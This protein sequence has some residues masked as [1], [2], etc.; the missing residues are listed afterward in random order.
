MSFRIGVIGTG[1]I[2]RLHARILSEVAA[3]E[4]CCVYDANTEAAREVAKTHGVKASA[5]LEEFVASVDAATLATPTPFHFSIGKQLLEAGRHV[6]I[7]KPITENTDDARE[8]V[9]IAKGRG[10][11]LQVGHVERFNPVL[12]ALEN[13]LHQPRF[14][15]SHRLSPYPNRSTDIGVVLDLMIHDIEIILHLVRSPV[16]SV[17][18]VGVPV[19]SSSEDIAN[20]RLRFEN[21]CVANLT[22]SRVSPERMRKIRVFQEDCYLSLDYMKQEGF[23]YRMAEDH[24]KESSLLAKLFASGDTTIVSEFAGRKILREPVPIEKGEPLKRELADFVRCA[25]AGAEPKVS[26]RE[27][28][29]ALELALDITRRIQDHQKAHPAHPKAS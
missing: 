10:L 14:I 4:F 28:T 1:H 21:G 8:L 15:E 17:D 23:V 19:L 7:E 13:R 5:S 3:G 25:K 27:G 2:G 24:R 29:A 9:A 18:A 11:A 26:G 6:L 12:S 20:A 22:V 16:V